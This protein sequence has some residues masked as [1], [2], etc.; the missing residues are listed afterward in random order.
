MMEIASGKHPLIY[1][2][3]GQ[4]GL[5]VKHRELHPRFCDNLCGK[6][7]RVCPCITESLCFTAEII[8]AL[9]INCNLI[10]L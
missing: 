6:K 7:M 5:A 10:K 8:T 9:E 2:I 1:G 4:S 3:D